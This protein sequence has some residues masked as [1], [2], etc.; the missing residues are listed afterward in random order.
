MGFCDHDKIYILIDNNSNLIGFA[1]DNFL[2]RLLLHE[3][4]H[5]VASLNPNYFLVTFKPQLT[6]FYKDLFTR[7]FK[8]KDS[9]KIDLIVEDFY[10]KLFYSNEAADPKLDM[11]RIVFSFNL[12]KKYSLLKKEEFEKVSMDYVKIVVYHLTDQH[13]NVFTPNNKYILREP[14]HVYKDKFGFFPITKNCVQELFVPSEVIC[15][16]TEYKQTPETYKAIKKLV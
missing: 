5:M 9:K 16:I 1:K 13:A 7:L 12:L 8:L 3:L 15:S 11:H 10:K 6:I 2:A 4:M 14:Y